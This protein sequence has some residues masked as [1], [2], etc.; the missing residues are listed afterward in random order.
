MSSRVGA[1]GTR[2]DSDVASDD[3]CD[4][5]EMLLVVEIL[6][7]P[8]TDPRRKALSFAILFVGERTRSALR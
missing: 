6:V 7:F 2:A 8:D 3:V 5:P 4:L 1:P